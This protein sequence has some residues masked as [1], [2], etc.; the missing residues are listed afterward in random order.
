MLKYFYTFLAGILSVTLVTAQPAKQATV[1]YKN[2]LAFE[3]KAMFNEAIASFKKA[4][5]LNKK[6]DSAYLEAAT[7]YSKISLPDSAIWLLNSAIKTNPAF[8]NGY[9]AIGSI[10]RNDK[11]NIDTAIIYYLKA[12]QKDSLNK[13]FFTDLA[14]CYNA[15]ENYREAVK[16]G[17]KAL[18]ID[19]NYK[20]AYNELGH[21]YRALKAY[22][23]CI[24]QFKK[25]LAISV[26]ELPLLYSGYCYTELHQKEDALK[27][28]EALNKLNPKM[29]SALKKKIDAMQ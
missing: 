5:S 8:A 25:N 21:A 2:G 10:Y 24:A 6:Y 14:W 13:L 29:A 19:N 3:Q 26:N 11:K 20:S 7:V 28:Y 16:Y 17:V 23:E 15:K 1:F 4:I 12:V 27:I 22:E 9:A 18:D